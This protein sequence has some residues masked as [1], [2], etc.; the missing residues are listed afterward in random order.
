[1]KVKV[2]ESQIGI[3]YIADVISTCDKNG[4]ECIVDDKNG[5]IYYYDPKRRKYGDDKLL[6]DNDAS[7]W[8]IVSDEELFDAILFDASGAIF[9]DFAVRWNDLQKKEESDEVYKTKVCKPIIGKF[10]K[11][12]ESMDD[13]RDWSASEGE[14]EIV[15]N[16]DFPDA[17]IEAGDTE[18]FVVDYD[19]VL[20]NDYDMESNCLKEEVCNLIRKEYPDLDFDETDFDITNEREFWGDE[21]TRHIYPYDESGSNNEVAEALAK[22]LRV[23]VDDVSERSGEYE[24]YSPDHVFGVKLPD[25]SDATYLVYDDEES[26][27]TSAVDDLG[28]K[29]QEDYCNLGAAIDYFGFDVFA[30]YI[31]GLDED[32]LD[33]LGELE[34]EM[35]KEEFAKY[36]QDNIGVDYRGFAEYNIGELGPAWH[37][38]E[39]D[40]KEIELPNGML[41]YR[42]D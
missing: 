25:G 5:D 26:A 41:A 13:P 30:E 14:V 9:K 4:I 28:E 19:K 1:M 33:D 23:S 39:Y 27:V 34:D 8:D 2:S 21:A 20:P 40:S 24:Y 29:F 18:H 17:D 36:I 15:W 35:D 38:A 7:I 11:V 37:L 31:N 10:Q 42:V 16:T 22:E 3:E 6:H 12:D 32:E